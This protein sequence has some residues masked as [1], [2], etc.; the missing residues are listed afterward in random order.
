MYYWKRRWTYTW[1]TKILDISIIF[2]CWFHLWWERIIFLF[3]SRVM[4]LRQVPWRHKDGS[5]RDHHLHANLASELLSSRAPMSSIFHS[6][7]TEN[8]NGLPLCRPCLP[9]TNSAPHAGADPGSSMHPSG[10]NSASLTFEDYESD[11]RTRAISSESSAALFSNADIF[12]TNKKHWVKS[13]E[14][15]FE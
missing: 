7:E 10:E 9:S 6:V 5:W 15:A 13:I 14:L 3:P 2:L 4:V 1:W 11:W 12:V 8:E